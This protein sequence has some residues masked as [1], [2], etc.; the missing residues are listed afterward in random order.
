MK[1]TALTL[2]V[3]AIGALIGSAVG[4]PMPLLTGA[5]LALIAG[6]HVVRLLILS[7]LIPLM[8]RR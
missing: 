6:L 5:A 3:G 7:A 1:P 8:L 4:L 2:V